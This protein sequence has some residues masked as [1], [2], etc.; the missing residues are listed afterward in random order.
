MTSTMPV[1]PT[2]T[3]AVATTTPRRTI[4]S[5]FASTV[6]THVRRLV[7]TVVGLCAIMAVPGTAF[8]YTEPVTHGSGTVPGVGATLSRTSASHAS[9]TGWV[10]TAVLVVGVVV[11]LVGG[12]AVVAQ[13]TARRR[14][15]AQP[16]PLHA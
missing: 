3:F 1:R 6:V 12:L 16:R 9:S 13:R 2:D 15:V 11:V 14:H 5:G 8:A 7:A 10:M 4:Q